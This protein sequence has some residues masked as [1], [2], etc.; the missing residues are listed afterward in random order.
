MIKILL[1]VI[2]LGMIAYGGTCVYAN[3][4]AATGPQSIYDAPDAK[5]AS[6]Y[7]II[8]NTG[9][10]M[11]T[12][13]FDQ[14]GNVYVLHGFWEL[15]GQEFKY[16]NRDLVLDQAVFGTVTIRARGTE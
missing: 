6:Y 1:L 9:N 16:R 12:D 5:D 15:V 2:L 8:E 7:V 13:S 4:F 3:F 10:M 11:F 14:H